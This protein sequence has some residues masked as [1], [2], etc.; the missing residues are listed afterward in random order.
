MLMKIS[1]KGSLGLCRR[2]Q[3]KPWFDEEC[4]QF[5]D[6]RKQDKRQWLQDPNQTNINKLNS[7]IRDDSR[8]FKGEKR[9]NI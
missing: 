6:Q 9:W 7:V 2:K 5:L 8:H 1:A 4:S 3:N